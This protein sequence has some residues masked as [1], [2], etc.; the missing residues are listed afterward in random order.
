MGA[1]VKGANASTFEPRGGYRLP[2]DTQMTAELLGKLLVDYRSK[3][4]NRLASLRKAYEGD[5]D[6]LHQ[7]EKAEYKPDNRLVANFAKQI[8]DSMVGYFLG[9][10]IRTTADDEA[11]AE[12]LDVWSAV[13]DSDDLDAEL[14]KLADIYGAGYELMWRDE[15]A[16]ARSCSVTPLNCFVVRDDTVEN[17]IIYAVRFWLDDNLFDNARDTLRGTLYDSMFETPFVMDGSKVI[18]GEPII[19]GFDDVPVVEYVD[20]EERLGLFEGVMSLINAYNKAISEKANDVEYYADAYLKIIGA[21]LDEQTLQNLRDSRIIN[22]D[23]RDSANVTV[24]FLSKPDADG[25]QENFIDRVERLIFV[26]SMVSDLSSEK[27]DTS[28]GIAI[29]YRLQA[30][31]DIAVVKQ[32]KFRRSLSRRWKLLCNYAGNT[33]LDAKAWTTVR[34]TFTRNLPS[35]LLEESQI[36][37]NLSGITSE[38][39]Q[40]SV[41]SCVDSPQAEM[42][43]MAD[44]RAEQAAQ[45]VPD[46]TDGGAS[47][48]GLKSLNGAQTQSL[49]SVIAQYAA[50]SLSEA[51]AISVISASIGVDHDKARSILL[52][53]AMPEV[54]K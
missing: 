53:D 4:V 39:T 17:D 29:K 16:F 50:G 22:L 31:S 52:G 46:R 30:M 33:R 49:L 45:M 7:K 25:T 15:E 5:H 34:A 24:E 36:A 23:S 43:R 27:F 54:V 48:G 1:D 10:P 20:N 26:L 28:S 38:E 18:F 47:D 19:H 3:Q 40:L 37:G 51:Q 2:K 41:L 14:S 42:Q 6:I 9:V 32:R 13:N 35:N 11:F 8:V 21:R 44:E 12:Y